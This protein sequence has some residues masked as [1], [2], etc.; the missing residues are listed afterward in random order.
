M[1]TIGSLCAGAGG[2]EQGLEATNGFV[3]SWQVEIDPFCR[4]VLEKHWPTIPRYSDLTLLNGSELAAVDLVSAGFPCQPVS[5]ATSGKR[6]AQDDNRWI[7]PDIVRIIGNLRP[8][9]RFVLLENTPGL[10]TAGSRYIDD[11]ESAFGQ[12]LGDLVSIGRNA[13]WACLRASE[14]GASH[15]RDRVFIVS[16]L[17][18]TNGSGFQ[19][20]G[21]SVAMAPT[22]R[23][24]KRGGGSGV[25]FFGGKR[26]GT[27]ASEPSMG[28]LADGIS[29][30]LVR[31][32]RLALKAL[33]NAVVPQ[34]AE[35]I[36]RQ[37]L[38]YE[39]LK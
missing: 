30:K 11:P 19:Q 21:G 22:C 29:G 8:A 1:L 23:S 34:V 25:G 4:S 27:W 31:H 39:R 5:I 26:G 35:Y 10:L 2:L 14:F 9:P 12:V 32:N 38:E 18:N 28:M 16:T 20:S 7:W 3:V 15:Y 37:I 36:G 33:G 17:A 13:E 24:V 6:R